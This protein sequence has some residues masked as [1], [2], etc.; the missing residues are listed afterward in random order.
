MLGAIAGDIIGT[1]PNSKPCR[2]P[3]ASLIGPGNRYTATTILT[4][5]TAHTLL[6]KGD[7][8][9]IY[10][11]YAE[12]FPQIRDLLDAPIG[13]PWV[14]PVCWAFSGIGDVLREAGIRA[15][16]AGCCEEQAREAQTLAAAVFWAKC[17]LSK[18]EIRAGLAGRFG[19]DLY[20]EATSHSGNPLTGALVCFLESKSF[21]QTVR[22]ALSAGGADAGNRAAIA[23]ALAEAYDGGLPPRIVGEVSKRLPGGFLEVVRQFY[24]KHRLSVFAEERMSA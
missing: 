24:H 10:E 14:A 9:G 5:A 23:G 6:S 4:V 20:G 2:D 19:L 22:A 11:K 15:R 12:R 18:E 8:G 16:A 21:D 1:I 17:G 13:M 7:A 3:V